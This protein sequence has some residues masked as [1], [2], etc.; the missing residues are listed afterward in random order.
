MFEFGLTQN[1]AGFKTHDTHQHRLIFDTLLFRVLDHSVVNYC[2]YLLWSFKFLL[3]FLFLILTTATSFCRVF[4]IHFRPVLGTSQII[5]LFLLTIATILKQFCC[6]L[7]SICHCLGC[8]VVHHTRLALAITLMSIILLIFD[9]IL[10]LFTF[11][12]V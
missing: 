9:I 2:F 6:G 11:I 7:L 8:E 4:A 3:L 10:H 5:V 1:A 12:L